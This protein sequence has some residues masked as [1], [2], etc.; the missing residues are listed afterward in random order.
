MIK[1]FHAFERRS[2]DVSSLSGLAVTRFIVDVFVV[3]VVVIII[4]F[5]GLEPLV[6]S[7]L[8]APNSYKVSF[9]YN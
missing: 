5:C 6:V 8:A 9:D 4:I 7:W 3:V 2:V 1:P